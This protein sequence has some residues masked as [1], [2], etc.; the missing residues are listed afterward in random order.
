MKKTKKVKIL[1]PTLVILLLCVV[2]MPAMAIGPYQ[3][4]QVDHNKNLTTFGAALGNLRG[5]AAGSIYWIWVEADQHWIKWQF[6]DPQQA[7][8]LLSKAIV[9]QYPGSGTLSAYFTYLSG[10]EL[11]NMWI[12]L[13]GDGAQYPGQFGP[14]GNVHGMLYWF[15]FG[16]AKLA[17][18]SDLVAAA[19]AAGIVSTYPAGEIW[20]HND[21]LA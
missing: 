14:P 9:A 13:S 7:K 16:S 2:A 3:A 19:V 11:D 20:K 21:I 8:G 1:I 5:G 4:F 18:A 12:Y 15:T 6:Q 17:G 10:D